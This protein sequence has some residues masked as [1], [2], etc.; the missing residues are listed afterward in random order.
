ME[1][2]DKEHEERYSI[3]LERADIKGDIERESAM[4][5]ISGNRDLFLKSN[6]MYDFRNDNFIFNFQADENGT[7]K[8]LW[9]ASLSRAE[10]KLMLLAFSLY[11]GRNYVGVVDLFSVLDKNNKR[12]AINAINRAY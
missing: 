6:K 9:K 3:L 1:F 11:S 7:V 8:I 2:L 5:I 12:L 4:Y 10:E